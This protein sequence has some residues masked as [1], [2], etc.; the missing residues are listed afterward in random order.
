LV[1]YL[2][3]TSN[4]EDKINYKVQEKMNLFFASNLSK[5]V[6]DVYKEYSSFR[7]FKYDF[8]GVEEL[9]TLLNHYTLFI[10]QVN[11]HQSGE[12]IK[13]QK[14]TTTKQLIE[15]NYLNRICIDSVCYPTVKF[16]CRIAC[17]Y[18]VL[19]DSLLIFNLWAHGLNQ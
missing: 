7:D 12:L 11:S 2:H 3:F 4:L 17:N 19:N 18:E 1:E 14:I 10:N 16:L 13:S 8:L 15:N 5:I 9:D 6:H